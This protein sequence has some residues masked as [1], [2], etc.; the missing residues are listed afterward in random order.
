MPNGQASS[1]S[2]QERKEDWNR[3][4]QWKCHQQWIQ[5]GLEIQGSHH[6]VVDSVVKVKLR[7]SKEESID[8]F[9]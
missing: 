3:E 2:F 5:C 9:Y 4:G 1:E 7:A 6:L 8:L